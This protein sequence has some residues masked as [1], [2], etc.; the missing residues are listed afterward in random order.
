MYKKTENT[1]HI[2]PAVGLKRKKLQ[3][4]TKDVLDTKHAQ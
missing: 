2:F 3:L 1:R 4:K